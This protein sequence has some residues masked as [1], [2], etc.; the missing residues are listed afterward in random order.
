MAAP[1]ASSTSPLGVVL[2]AQHAGISAGTALSGATVYDGDTLAA[3]TGGE[4]R[5]GFGTSQ[6]YLLPGST[7]VVHQTGQGFGA[8]LT[9]GTVILSSLEGGTFRLVA[10]GAV[11]RPNTPAATSGQITRLGPSELLLTARKGSLQV[12]MDD[13]TKTVPEGT[14]VRML[15]QPTDAAAPPAAPGS[16]SVLSAGRDRFIFIVLTLVAAGVTVGIIET[17]LSPSRP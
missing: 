17:T 14:S 2:Q 12:A 8:T 13:E 6:A 15:I 3:Y 1:A 5:V 16:P 9:N 4:L 10:D 11:I 7:A